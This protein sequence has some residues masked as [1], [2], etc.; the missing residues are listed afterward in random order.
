[1]PTVDLTVFVSH[2]KQRTNTQDSRA[3]PSRQIQHLSSH[4]E[5]PSSTLTSKV[6][7]GWHN[8]HPLPRDVRQAGTITPPETNPHCNK[9]TN[10]PTLSTLPAAAATMHAYSFPACVHVARQTADKHTRQPG[11]SKQ[12]DSRSNSQGCRA[13]P[14]TASTN[15]VPGWRNN[16]PTNHKQPHNH[17][18][19]CLVW[20]TTNN[21][22]P[23]AAATTFKCC[24]IYAKKGI[25]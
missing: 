16:S 7:A 12:A 2:A 5:M 20:Q 4:K 23:P 25:N 13:M 11:M 6:P 15:K 24:H 3:C 10:K 9:P 21:H 19:H 17:K 18:P 8:Q 1:M 14:S 22:T